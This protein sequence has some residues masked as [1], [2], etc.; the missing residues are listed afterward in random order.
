VKPEEMTNISIDFIKR[1]EKQI[2]ASRYVVA[3][4]AN[5]ESLKLYYA[6]G[7]SIDEQLKKLLA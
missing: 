7:K 5:A 3:K 1:L 2:F 4:I 6:I